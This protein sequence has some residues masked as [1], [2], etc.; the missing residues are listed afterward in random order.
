VLVIPPVAGAGGVVGFVVGL[1]VGLLVGLVVGL[2]VGLL[3]GLRRDCVRRA[4]VVDGFAVGVGV[5]RGVGVV[6][7][8]GREAERLTDGAGGGGAV[9]AAWAGDPAPLSADEASLHPVTSTATDTVTATSDP[10]GARP[11]AVR[12]HVL[13]VPATLAVIGVS[14]GRS[15][16]PRRCRDK[17]SSPP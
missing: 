15:P 11:R 17:D 14:L 8:G 5:T 6:L 3:V 9:A 4:V 2:L 1:L 12:R 10:R 16:A 13:V 7:L